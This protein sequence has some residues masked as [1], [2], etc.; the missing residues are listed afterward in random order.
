[1]ETLHILQLKVSF[2]PSLS[3]KASNFEDKGTIFSF[4]ILIRD[5]SMRINVSRHGIKRVSQDHV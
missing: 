1:M 2:F 3:R 4:K 5:S